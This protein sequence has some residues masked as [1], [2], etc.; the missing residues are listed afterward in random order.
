[1]GR[2]HSGIVVDLEHQARVA[3]SDKFMSDLLA[4]GSGMTFQALLGPFDQVPHIGHSERRR[5][6]WI[7]AWPDMGIEPFFGRP[8]AAF[9]TD[10]FR[11]V[12]EISLVIGMD[13]YR[14]AGKT[15]PALCRLGDLQILG[16]EHGL[17]SREH[18]IGLGVSVFLRPDVKLILS[19]AKCVTCRTVSVTGAS[20]TRGSAHVRVEIIGVGFLRA[21]LVLV[22]GEWMRCRPYDEHEQRQN[23]TDGYQSLL[24]HA[25]CRSVRFQEKVTGDS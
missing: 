7:K 6:L 25:F 8:M 2:H 1:M 11:Y 5:I 20:A 15:A 22:F 12:V 3:G 18:F 4:I 14:M 17:C 21:R 9:A 24:G 10:P 13:C 16:N 19:N 23:G